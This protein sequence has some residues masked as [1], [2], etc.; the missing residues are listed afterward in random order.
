MKTVRGIHL[1]FQIYRSTKGI[2]EHKEVS[3]ERGYCPSEEDKCFPGNDLRGNNFEDLILQRS[4]K[5]L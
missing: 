2:T 1:C 3:T 4:E 5:M